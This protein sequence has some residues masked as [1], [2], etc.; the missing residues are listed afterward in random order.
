[1]FVLKIKEN[2]IT[3]WQQTF[4]VKK[5][6]VLT[7]YFHT[8]YVWNCNIYMSFLLITAESTEPCSRI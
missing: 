4:S 8:Q 6:I 1:M 5:L 3:F 7:L 2:P